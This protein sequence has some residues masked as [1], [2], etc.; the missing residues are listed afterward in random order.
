MQD[1]LNSF[2]DPAIHFD[3]DEQ[4]KKPQASQGAAA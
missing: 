4:I 1:K 3:L 2:L